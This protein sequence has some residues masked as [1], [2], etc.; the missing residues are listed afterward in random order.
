MSLR[1]LITGGATGLGKALARCWASHH[2]ANIKICIA[3][4]HQ[5]R[6]EETVNQ[7]VTMGAD[8]M[9]FPC[10]ITNLSDI[11]Q[12][13]QQII[14]QWQGIDIVI[15]N[16]GV[17]TGGSFPSESIEQW[18]WI[19]DINLIGMVR[20][21]QAFFDIFKRQGHGH[22]INIASQAGLTP[23]PLMSSYNAVKSAVISLSETMRLEFIPH[24][25]K[26]NV[27]CPSF[28]KTNLNESIRS[29]ESQSL[30]MM[31][32]FF[33]RGELSADQV[34]QRIYRQVEQD[35]FLILTHDE[36]KK[37]YFMKKILPVSLYLS[38]MRKKTKAMLTKRTAHTSKPS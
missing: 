27:V 28:F 21:S 16:A 37:A 8:A 19:F 14:E 5:S 17:A 31:N 22:F 36:G 34:A 4:I 9:F 23:V 3:D 25:I 2:Q 1:I 20:V 26:V 35:K 18:Q 11:E 29:S 6:G 12:M 10:D 13:K 7:L 24:H 15:N 32:K 30:K 38:L 33:E